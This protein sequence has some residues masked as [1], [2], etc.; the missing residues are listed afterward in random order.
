MLAQQEDWMMPQER[1][2]LVRLVKEDVETA[3]LYCALLTEDM[4]IPWII[5]EL[6][7]VGVTVFHHKYSMGPLS[8]MF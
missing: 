5:D 4:R 6:G 8:A 3:D 7:K 2:A 1:L